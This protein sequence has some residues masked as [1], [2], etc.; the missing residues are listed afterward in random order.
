M[1]FCAITISL[2][3]Q[4]NNCIRP[5]PYSEPFTHNQPWRYNRFQSNTEDSCWQKF[6]TQDS[7]GFRWELGLDG[8]GPSVSPY[9]FND[10][11]GHRLH[12]TG[13]HYVFYIKPAHQGI[14]GVISSAES[15]LT[16][17]FINVDSL[18]HPELS[19]DYHMVGSDIRSLLI[20]Y[21]EY[22]DTVWNSIDSLIGEQQN[23]VADH[24]KRHFIAVN[25]Q[26]DTVQFRFVA[27]NSGGVNCNTLI[28]NIEVKEAENCPPPNRPHLIEVTATSAKL[29]F[30]K[31]NISGAT[32]IRYGD[33]GLPANSPLMKSITVGGDTA[34]ISGLTP[35]KIYYVYFGAACGSSNISLS[36]HPLILRLPC[37]EIFDFPFTE[38]FDDWM[39]DTIQYFNSGYKYEGVISS[40]WKDNGELANVRYSSWSAGLYT[41]V[42]RPFPLVDKSGSGNYLFQK[43]DYHFLHYIETPKIDLRNSVRPQISYWHH[44]HSQTPTAFYVEINNG[45]GWNKIDSLFAP[46]QSSVSDPWLQRVIDL[47]Q[48]RSDT[49][50]FRF[51]KTNLDFHDPAL[52]SLDEISIREKPGCALAGMDSTLELCDDL[53]N[54]A[55]GTLL[56]SM[57][58]GGSWMDLQNSGAIS[59]GNIV[60]LTLLQT[61]SA[62]RF[63]Y[64]IPADSNCTADSATFT[65]IRSS[66]FCD[67]GLIEPGNPNFK[68]FPNPAQG[69]LNIQYSGNGKISGLAVYNLEGKRVFTS[70]K[71][72]EKIDIAPWPAGLY[73][74]QITTDKGVYARRF[75]KE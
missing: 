5:A 37:I 39:G 45:S 46:T 61:D 23:N 33:I 49:V 50:Q 75:M 4:Q 67:M 55:L 54:L 15:Y 1:I 29:I 73:L 31:R 36:D 10:S 58:Y 62:Y 21:R 19:F 57:A 11:S 51:Y 13:N 38:N 71:P 7:L 72:V 68:I 16:T 26:S 3:A 35:G 8:G 6:P 28:D 25:F 12:E 70:E 64:T 18:N 63:R 22:G 48:Y 34:L 47:Y 53:H 32:H 17:P 14:I 56:D 60:D 66:A 43:Q 65:L 69:R 20:Q 74:L 52:V 9:H 42:A 30:D 24:L 41:S 27:V 2:L 59:A 44:S 40:C